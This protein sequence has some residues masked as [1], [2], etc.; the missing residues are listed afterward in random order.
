MQIVGFS[1]CCQ[2]PHYPAVGVAGRGDKGPVSG[3]LGRGQGWPSQG[4]VSLWLFPSL[5]LSTITISPPL[6]HA[7]WAVMIGKY[8]CY[9]LSPPS[10][11]A[12]LGVAPQF[13][14]SERIISDSVVFEEN[15][16]YLITQIGNNW[17]VRENIC[18]FYSSSS[19]PL[20]ALS[21]SSLQLASSGLGM[22]LRLSQGTSG[23]SGEGTKKDKGCSRSTPLL[24][25]RI[26]AMLAFLTSW[27][28]SP[29]GC[30]QKKIFFSSLDMMFYTLNYDVGE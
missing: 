6:G 13:H 15:K 5:T 29:L 1:N 23:L 8:Q 18:T 7:D 24:S 4:L 28:C 30:T 3:G 25:H 16:L 22:A 10:P 9:G 12:G 2:S 17:R 19:Q 21:E 20:L 27:S 11:G 14:S 26:R